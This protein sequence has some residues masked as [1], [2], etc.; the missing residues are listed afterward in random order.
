MGGTAS[1]ATAGSAI[2]PGWGTA[3]GAGIGTLGSLVGGKKSSGASEKAANDQRNQE[4]MMAVWQN[5]QNKQN[6]ID[7]IGQNNTITQQN[8]DRYN[9]TLSNNRPQ[10]VGAGGGTVGWS[11]D[12]N[13]RPVQTSTLGAASQGLYDQA[14]GVQSEMLGGLEGGF[15]VDNSVMTALRGLQQ[16]ELQKTR[17]AE[18]ARLAAMGLSTGSGTAWGNAQDTLNKAQSAADLQAILGGNTAW[19]NSQKNMRD[20]LV[21]ASGVGSAQIN[22][23]TKS[24]PNFALGTSATQQQ[25]GA[26]NFPNT[27]EIASNATN[28]G[29]AVG[30]AVGNSWAQ[31]GQGLGNLAGSVYN[32]WNQPTSNTAYNQSGGYAGYDPNSAG[33]GLTSMDSLMGTNYSNPYATSWS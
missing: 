29:N 1:G 8:Q 31:G 4:I 32:A 24:L 25:I 26:T 11:V 20:N 30:Q 28:Y 27:G 21:G 14:Q 6:Q 12:A 3:I 5:E 15:G 2:S 7:S 19:L 9:Q 22:D 16:P 13:G 17:D 23:F 33:Q 18:N 10:Q